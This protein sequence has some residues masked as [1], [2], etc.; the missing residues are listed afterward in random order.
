MVM[1]MFSLERPLEDEPMILMASPRFVPGMKCSRRLST[2]LAGL[3][4]ARSS[5]LASRGS[6]AF[7]KA[8]EAK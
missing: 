1:S 7:C 4:A 5:S 2:S 3:L 6:A 8:W